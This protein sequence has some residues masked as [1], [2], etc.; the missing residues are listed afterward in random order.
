MRSIDDVKLHAGRAAYSS[1]ERAIVRTFARGPGGSNAAL[2][3][4]LGHRA[5]LPLEPMGLPVHRALIR[6]SAGQGEVAGHPVANRAGLG[7]GP[8]QVPYYVLEA[9]LDVAVACQGVAQIL[10]W[11]SFRFYR[12]ST[13]V[14]MRRAVCPRSTMACA[15]SR[16][17]EMSFATDWA[18]WTD[19]VSVSN[20][21]L[22]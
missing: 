5:C 15:S 16:G 11:P 17:P 19:T 18:K 14:D 20:H 8:C 13:T 22:W 1:W 9:R 12:L 6:P 3:E 7:C 4:H 2:R 10:V 21:Q